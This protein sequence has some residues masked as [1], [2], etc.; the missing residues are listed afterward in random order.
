[1]KEVYWSKYFFMTI[2]LYARTCEAL[3]GRYCGYE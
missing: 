1:M 3:L 2:A